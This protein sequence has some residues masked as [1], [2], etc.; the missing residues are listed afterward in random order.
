M[1]GATKDLLLPTTITGSLPRPHWYTE[2]LNGRPFR[3]AMSSITF[4]EQYADALS[5]LIR[6]QERAGLD[7]L[8]D[9]D[10]RFDNDVGGRSWMLYTAQRLSGLQGVDL[11][12][13]YATD[14]SV[15]SIMREFSEAVT[16]PVVVDRVGR[17]PLEFTALWKVAQ[18]L[19]DKPVKFGAATPEVVEG[20]L[21]NRHYQDRAELMY[22]VSNA[23][24][25]EW[26]ELAEAGCQVVQ[27][28]EP[29]V[30]RAYY[31][32]RKD[33]FPKDFYVDLFNNTVRGLHEKTEVWCH[34][35]WGNPAAQ[36]VFATPMSYAPAIEDM[37]R[38]NCDVITFETVDNR[39]E[40]LELIG[41]L[42]TGKKIAIGAVSHR[43]LQVETPEDV[44]AIIRTALRYIPAERLVITSDCGFGREGMSRRHA[45]YKMASLVMGTNIV[46]RELGLEERPCPMADPRYSLVPSKEEE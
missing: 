46:R 11:V 23:L 20:A 4:R 25:E 3:V 37:N 31:R 44:A 29:W 5:S 14:A 15:G 8:T 35:C 32:Q 10:M 26:H 41:K 27:I 22:D 9:G 1:L 34:T 16:P 2:G 45:R 33:V 43:T 40:N 36:R 28:E 42:I 19:T 38:L 24:N 6:D 21:L 17:G 30:H 7:I 39:G 13:K 12:G 18:R